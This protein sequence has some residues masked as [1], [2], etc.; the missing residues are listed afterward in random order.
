MSKE[1][2]KLVDVAITALKTDS[3]HTTCKKMCTK[4]VCNQLQFESI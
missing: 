4:L 3:I 2:P 1:E